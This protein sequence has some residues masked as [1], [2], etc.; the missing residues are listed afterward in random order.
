MDGIVTIV[1]NIFDMV[2]DTEQD[3]AEIAN[4]IETAIH[5]LEEQ[6]DFVHALTN[7]SELML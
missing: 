6:R 5:E 2:E 3:F 4:L 7:Q 1:T